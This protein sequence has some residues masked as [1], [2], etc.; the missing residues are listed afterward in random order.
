[1]VFYLRY[2]DD[3]EWANA[4]EVFYQK[5]LAKLLRGGKFDQD[6]LDFLREYEALLK[7]TMQHLK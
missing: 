6:R 1:M 5:K 3:F 7:K 2:R 4:R